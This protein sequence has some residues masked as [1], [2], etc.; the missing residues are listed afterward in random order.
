MDRTSDYNLKNDNSNN[1]HNIDDNNNTNIDYDDGHNDDVGNDNDDSLSCFKS[2]L[3]IKKNLF[4]P[5][6]T[7]PRATEASFVS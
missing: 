2:I 1:S 4:Q 6:K 3:V 5:N 7:K